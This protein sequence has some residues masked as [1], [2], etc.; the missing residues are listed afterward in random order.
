MDVDTDQPETKTVAEKE[1]APGPKPTTPKI[2]K[3]MKFKAPEKSPKKRTHKEA[4]Q[5]TPVKIDL[6]EETAMKSWS[7]N[8]SSDIIKPDRKKDDDVMI[9]EDSED[10]KLVYEET[11]SDEAKTPPDDSSKKESP[12]DFSF[13]KQAKV[14]DI[15][16]PVAVP[17]MASPKAPRR[18][19]FVTL[20][21][22]KNAKKKL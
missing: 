4:Q 1:P 6:L 2:D 19:N 8:S 16:K 13:L 14:T 5:K 21:S 20:S 18:V 9:I 7:D 15:K 10:L 12:K 17:A 22:P 3:Y 11:K